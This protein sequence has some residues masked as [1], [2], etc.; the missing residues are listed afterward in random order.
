MKKSIIVI[1]VFMMASAAQ[2]D[3]P[4]TNLIQKLTSVITNLCPKAEIKVD[5]HAFSAKHD[6]MVYTIHSRSKTGEV[7]P[8]TYQK[9]GPG[10]RGFMLR[11]SLNDGKYGG[12]ACVPQTIQGPY[13]PTFLD[14][15]STDG[16]KKH[17]QVHF[18]YG[19]R[20]DPKL[21]KAILEAIPR[22]RFQQTD[23]AVTQESAPS[24]AP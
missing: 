5:K 6:T 2:A 9:E 19:G 17:Y 3:P 7:S 24:A 12:A 1:C 13:F 21:K 20:L 16:G 8:R 18:S 14:A 4:E 23:G 22:T 15:P 11:I 10:F